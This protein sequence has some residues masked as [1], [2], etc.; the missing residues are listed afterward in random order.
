MRLTTPLL[1]IL[2]ATPLMGAGHKNSE[3]IAHGTSRPNILYIYVDDMGWG[4]IGPNGQYDRKAKGLP[5]LIT[6]TLDR[7]ATE[8][9]NFRRSYGCTVCSPARSSQQTGFH[10]GHTFADQND[11]DNAKK[12]IRSE[13]VTM[14]DVLSA[15]GYVT[16][17]W[18]KWGYGG[19]KSQP[20]PEILNIQTLPTSHGYE[21]VVA[22][23]HHVR[24]HT[25]Y[26]PT[27]W[28]APA[29]PS[30]KGGL[31]LIPNSMERWAG[32]ASYPNTPALQNHPD[33]PETAYCDDVYAFAAL[34]FVRVQSQNYNATGQPFF[35]LL[36]LQ[37]PHAP[38]AE[39]AKLP[40]WDV[41]YNGISFFNEI[42]EQAQHWAAMISRIDGHIGNIL[43]SLDDPNGDGDRPDSV[44]ESTLIIFQSDNGGPG[45]ASREVFDAN[46]GL[47]DVKGRIEDGG[48][49]V[50]MMIRL[51]ADFAGSSK[52]KAGTNSD[53]LFDVTDFL[54]T[55]SEL[56]G[57]KAP[58]G[59]DGVSLAPILTG[60]G[61]Q[62]EREFL[63]HEAGNGQSII[64]GDDK[65]I[66]R[67]D[68]TFE[69]YDLKADHGEERDIA[70]KYPDMVKELKT[71]MLG[72]RVT[73]PKGFAN[74]YHHW[75]GE[76]AALTSADAN[77]SDYQYSN[78]GITYVTESGKP[79]VSWTSLMENKGNVD[80]LAVA[81]ED[82]EFL[83]LEI[84]GVTA[85]QSLVLDPYVS[86]T[87]RNEIRIAKH[88]S[89][90]VNQGT[91]S[92]LRWIEVEPG[93]VLRGNGA[94]EGSVYNAG[95]VSALNRLLVSKDYDQS[96]TGVL[97]IAMDGKAALE[98][99]GQ[100]SLGGQLKLSLA[101]KFKP[102]KG[103]SYELIN[104][105]AVMGKFLNKNQVVL[106]ED[107]T[108]FKISYSKNQVVLTAD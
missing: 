55:F 41:A 91:V 63:I 96:K 20:D 14:G 101:P 81:N 68:G 30:A 35:G 78:A 25:F 75:I 80:A 58:L 62:R 32:S 69:L 97:N 1:L 40:E 60:K 44:L 104:A 87:G 47:R 66:R 19:S 21:H 83:A 34:D 54:P 31:E 53:I 23:L 84:R 2:L 52:L 12:A 71:L 57:V 108:T 6:P 105:K 5:H 24:A 17:Y 29:S 59:I 67:K 82:L 39:V 102:R 79:K 92:T 90:V 3:L 85:V 7:L 70:S 98:V 48:I 106:F 4:A 46:G 36:A 107:G 74:T 95:E 38:F 22:E 86:L 65:L 72:E 61:K 76:N 18:G 27:L 51:P 8:G 56:A 89:L 10:Q 103:E 16:G 64:R 37:V 15:A 88:G 28:K 33:Y 93:G 45:G 11:T 73:E 43:S 99:S 13:D 9:V 50:P 94:I 42:P 26:Q 100:V 49:R 77:W